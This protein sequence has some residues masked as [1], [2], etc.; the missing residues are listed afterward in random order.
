M[1][2]RAIQWGKDS[3]DCSRDIMVT[4]RRL[5]LKTLEDFFQ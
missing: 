4:E 2:S 3:R 1:V 5:A